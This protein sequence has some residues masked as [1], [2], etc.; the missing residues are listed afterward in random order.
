MGD[1]LRWVTYCGLYCELCA[2]R[3]RIPAQAEALRASMDKEG[4]PFWGADFPNFKPFWEFLTDL[5]D[6]DNA[7][8]GCRAGG[9][10]PRCEI[11]KCAEAR[12][13]EVCARCEDFP[14]EKIEAFSRVYPTL[15]SDGLRLKR[16]G[17]KRWL[18][19]QQDRVRT[20]FA[21]VDVR[22]PDAD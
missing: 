5:T 9:G 3:G 22:H 20:G 2:Q 7:C 4:Y 11:R 6:R 17:L 18:A 19:E 10:F 13:V 12:G 1:S 16:I 14:C 15:I 21:Y 8:P